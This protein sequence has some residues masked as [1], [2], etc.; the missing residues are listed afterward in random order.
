MELYK[1]RVRKFGKRHANYK[2]IIDII[3]LFRP[4]II[5]PVEGYQQIN[6]YG[7]FKSYFKIA[8]R[9]LLRDKTI[10]SINLSGLAIGVAVAILLGVWVVDELNYNR[11]FQSFDRIG[12]VYH[13]LQFGGDHIA[14]DGV[15]AQYGKELKADISEFETVASTLWP[16]NFDLYF[17]N[18]AISKTGL[19]V[20]PE[21]IDL[22]SVKL[23]GGTI[24][25]FHDIHSVLLSKSLATDL[26]GNDP[27]GKLVKVNKKYYAKVGGLFEDFPHNSEFGNV[28]MLFPLSY[29][30]S[31]NEE[32]KMQENNWE[33]YHFQ[34]FVK[35]NEQTTFE[36]AES[37]MKDLLY[38]RAS[39]DGKA[40]NPKGHLFPMQKWHL[41]AK[42][43]DGKMSAGTISL[44]WM[45]GA[46]GL[47]VLLL[48]CINFT[49]LTTARS[50][51][52]AKEVGIRKV[53][54]SVRSQLIKQFLFESLFLVSLA[55]AIALGLSYA[56]L[57]FLNEL[58]G[59]NLTIPFLDPYFLII[60]ITT[61]LITSFLAGIYPSFY[62][63]SFN[64]I[65]VLKGNFRRIRFAFNPRK[66]M[67]VFQF[68][69]S[70]LLIIGTV[71]VSLQIQH[72]KNRPTGF[73]REGIIHLSIYD[74]GFSKLKYNSLRQDLIATG[75]V[76]DMAVSDFPIT[77]GMNANAA[78]TWEGKDPSFKPLIA[79]NQCSHDFPKTNG[80]QFV[81]G[82]DFS[83]E[84]STDSTGII[85]NEMGAKLISDKNIIG[86]KI[87]FGYGVEREV[88]GVI[89]DQIRWTPYVNQSPHIYYLGYDNARFLT[90]RLA[91]GAP[92][93]N[94]LQNIEQVV[95]KYD[96]EGTF[97]Y[98][99]QDEDYARMFKNEERIGQMA[100]VFSILSIFISCIGM[101][102]LASFAA[103]QRTKEIGIRKV[104]GATVYNLWKMLSQEF[105]TL[106][107]VS[108]LISMPI[109]YYCMNEWLLG[110]EYRTEISWW[111][112]VV[113]GM[114][115]LL[116][117]L[118]TVSYQS[119]KAAASNPVNSLRSE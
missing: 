20:E 42:L 98:K 61:I 115:T 22:F 43:A 86:K 58:A 12:L 40:L 4:G 34:C 76:K 52:R 90:I 72:A 32:N 68:T 27:V 47:F 28:K 69:I 66:I 17:E 75:F 24:Q 35:I 104:L 25:N 78:L 54:G 48:A 36:Q 50:E 60:S 11:S 71:V 37:K 111:V 88:I 108:C 99:F 39:G 10:T 53:M 46:I 106:V 101:F 6:H 82:R 70:V 85:I 9:V 2:F 100:G 26:I 57:P 16:E 96:P 23:Y 15:P 79:L 110:Y 113:S 31:M 8:S 30:F 105:I 38:K 21:F 41:F 84:H 67:V 87:T 116:I 94:A 64:P 97:N 118:I 56:G 13:D 117:T 109:A 7:M 74:L 59:K 107:I 45:M 14:H 62:L 5:R 81:E 92:T 103:G 95:K 114:G 3:L 63:S 89:K 65:N 77:G 1:E 44:V 112:F 33:D 102:G 51:K 73:D 19:F 93:Q 80:F 91:T 119:I 18:N 55:F 29:Y 83:R 49:N